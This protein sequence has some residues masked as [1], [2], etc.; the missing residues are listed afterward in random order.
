MIDSDRHT[1]TGS[2]LLDRVRDIGALA[3][4]R[5]PV[6]KLN[7]TAWGHSYEQVRKL[8]HSESVPTA[9]ATAQSWSATPTTSLTNRAYGQRRTYCPWNPRRRSSATLALL[10]SI[11]FL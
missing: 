11:M 4:R 6:E 8:T 1:L 5:G 10:P 9:P 2:E 3:V 7:F